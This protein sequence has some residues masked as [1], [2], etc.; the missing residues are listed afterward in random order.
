MV[1]FIAFLATM[2]R[3]KL[4]PVLKGRTICIRRDRVKDILFK[5]G[6]F[7]LLLLDALQQRSAR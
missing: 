3:E 5:N 7:P 2:I 6:V 4:L 1:F